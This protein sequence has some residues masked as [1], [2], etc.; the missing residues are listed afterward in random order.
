MVSDRA[1]EVAR[2][3]GPGYNGDDRNPTA[4]TAEPLREAGMPRWD[5]AWKE[6]LQQL[7][8]QAVELLLPALHAEID[9]A[10]GVEFL[11]TEL[12][13]AIRGARPPRGVVDLLARVWRRDGEETWLLVHVEVQRSSEPGFALRMF[14][15]HE[16][17]RLRF[18]RHPRSV[19]LLIDDQPDWRPTRYEHAD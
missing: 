1:S 15:Y 17:I 2:A 11:E 6:V 4:G 12:R 14:D 13:Q 19:A 7:F 3:T 10:R 16:R 5:A 18:G 9:W 8:P